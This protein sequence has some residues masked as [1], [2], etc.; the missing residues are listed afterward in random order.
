MVNNLV[1]SNKSEVK[2]ESGNGLNLE[3]RI[4]SLVNASK[5]KI[6]IS[7]N[8]GITE[9]Y[10]NI[11]H[12]INED[13]LKNKRA[14][15]GNY[16]VKKISET[17]TLKFGKGWSPKQI[18]RFMQFAKEFSREKVATLWRQLTWSHI[19]QLLPMENDLKRD[20]YIEMCRLEN[21][22]V[23]TL[24]ARIDSMLYER[25][26]ISKKPENTIRSELEHLQ[27]EEKL[28]PDLVF[29][30]PY[31][32]DFLDLH[33]SYSERDFEQAIIAEMENF[34]LEIGTDFAFMGRQKRI[35]VDNE[36]YY[37]DLLFFH[38]RLKCLVAIELKLGAFKAQYKGQMELYLNYLEKNLMRD[39]EEKPIGLILC[40]GKNEEHIELMRLDKSNIRV[41]DYLTVLPSKEILQEKLQ[42]SIERAKNR[43]REITEKD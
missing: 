42:L 3:D 30:D 7:V 40:A 9:L 27:S 21:W 26:L 22:S 18:H 39:G 31:L 8:S 37:I 13:V 17:L 15:Y 41:A 33:D 25:T 12:L 35:T 1:V 2:S 29:R 24:S 38:R 19:K 6:A 14:D 43:A 16:V 34:I 4:V 32:L 36:D 20:F 10:W 23:R 11:G 5:I 28:S